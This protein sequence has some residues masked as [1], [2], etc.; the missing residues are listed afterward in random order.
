YY[1]VKYFGGLYKLD[2]SFEKITPLTPPGR[3]LNQLAFDGTYFYAIGY[4]TSDPP[5]IY[6]FTNIW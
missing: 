1:L 6:K 3:G 2:G 4:G 5:K